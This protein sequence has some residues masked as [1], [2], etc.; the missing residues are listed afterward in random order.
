MTEVGTNTTGQ[1]ASVFAHDIFIIGS[2]VYV[3]H[4]ESQVGTI[5]WVITDVD[6]APFTEK[7]KDNPVDFVGAIAYY[8]VVSGLFYYSFINYATNQTS[9]ITYD[10]N[11][12]VNAAIG[13]SQLNIHRPS[14]SESQY[15]VA[16]DGNNTLYI[17]LENSG[18]G[19]DYLITY[20]ITGDAFTI[21]G[22]QNIAIMSDRN[23]VSGTFEKAFHLTEDK[24]YQ[25]NNKKTTQLYLISVIAQSQSNWNAITDTFLFDG[26]NVFEFK[27]LSSEVYDA[28]ISHGRMNTP[29]VNMCISDTIKISSGMFIQLT[30]RYSTSL[31]TPFIYKATYNFED[32]ADG[33][34]GNAID[35]FHSFSTT[36]TNG[37]VVI[38]ASQDGHRKVVKISG[39]GDNGT[40]TLI[41]LGAES[42][43][44]GSVE[45]WMKYI[46]NG[47]GT[48]YIRFRNQ[49]AT[50][51]GIIFLSSGANTISAQYGNGAG[52][53]TTVNTALASDTW[54]H[55]R[56]S[57]D[58]TTDK[59]SLWFDGVNMF[60]AQNFRSDA[61]ATTYLEFNF[62]LSE[63]TGANALEVYADAIG[64]S[65][66]ANYN[67][68]DNLI[69][70]GVADQVVF[71]GLVQ[72]FTEEPLQEVSIRSQA[73]E[74][75]N[76]FPA[77]DFSGSSQSIINTLITTYASYITAGT[78][79]A[80]QAMGTITFA[81]DYTLRA[82]LTDFAFLNNFIWYLTPLGA[83][84]FNSGA[85]DSLFEINESTPALN[86]GRN[87]GKRA[88][89]K[90]NIKGAI[91]AG[92]QVA[93]VGAEDLPDQQQ[94]GINPFF[95]TVSWLNTQSLCNI[96]ETN[97]LSRKGTQA[98]IPRFSDRNTSIGFIQP[99]ETVTFQFVFDKFNIPS[100]QFGIEL[101]LY[102]ARQGIG[103]YD[104]SD[105][106]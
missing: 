68:G 93:G 60:T 7:D 62:E 99:G 100:G 30:D 35:G 72:E 44:S 25:I 34:S 56:W 15:G 106:L 97:I 102:N 63:A 91:V 78:L 73:I 87:R 104:I 4:T 16:F 103:T 41:F 6:T 92:T 84:Q 57:F 9:S 85:I 53:N 48:H 26:G 50:I 76:I 22:L 54:V 18:D 8:G 10:S 42:E 21:G 58:C 80:G 94:F 17:I 71:E 86:V 27:D 23:T 55:I 36:D 89:N 67:V 39:D 105:V 66:D 74:M 1:A 61:V 90:V 28:E 49:D 43:T 79:A 82:I 45:L 13:A 47:V 3:S 98:T 2:N 81:G 101:T 46:D 95:R 12:P 20:S 31:N 29:F 96:M 65:W 40:S 88:V 64:H 14:D 19:L 83:L 77:G 32:E 75:D 5:F 51:I 70:E 38:V 33:T 37:V 69:A 52:G 11:S 24:I 59:Q